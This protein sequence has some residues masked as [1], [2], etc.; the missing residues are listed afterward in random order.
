MAR[1]KKDPYGGLDP[2][3]TKN[4]EYAKKHLIL[5]DGMSMMRIIFL[6]D[7]EPAEETIHYAGKAVLCMTTESQLLQLIF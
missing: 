4:I 5:S 3:I 2:L 7:A 1:K 6:R